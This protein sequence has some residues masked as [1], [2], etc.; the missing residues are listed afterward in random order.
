MIF[1]SL[2]VSLRNTSSPMFLM[3]QSIDS[4]MWK[5]LHRAYFTEANF[6][7]Q[8]IPAM[9]R[10]DVIS[11]HFLVADIDGLNLV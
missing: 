5:N 9:N 8:N 7:N 10:R 1:S 4:I 11:C 2:G 6:V 3:A